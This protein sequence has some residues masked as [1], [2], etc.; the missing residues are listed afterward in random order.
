MELAL[1]VVAFIFA[2]AI[3]AAIVKAVRRSPGRWGVDPWGQAAY[4]WHDGTQWT[5]HTRENED[6]A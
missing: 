2:C 3:I 5:Q 1:L 4:R 6:N